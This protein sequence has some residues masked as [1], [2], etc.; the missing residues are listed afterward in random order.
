MSASDFDSTVVSDRTL[1]LQKR[2][3]ALNDGQ[4]GWRL[5]RLTSYW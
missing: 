1:R 2:F 5:R 3:D 4:L